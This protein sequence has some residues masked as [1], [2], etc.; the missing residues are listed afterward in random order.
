[1]SEKV[2]RAHTSVS[3]RARAR[4]NAD[5][6]LVF[7]TVVDNPFRVKWPV[8]PL[9]VQNAVL[10]GVV[11]MLAVVAEYNVAREQ[12]SRRKRKRSHSTPHGREAERANALCAVSAPGHE[13]GTNDNAPSAASGY[14]RDDMHMDVPHCAPPILSSLTVGINQVTKRLERLACSYR[15]TM[16]SNSEKT[17]TS[18]TPPPQCSYLVLACRAD[19]DPPNLIG[20]I[21]NLVAALNSWR[22]ASASQRRT[23]LV[24]LPKGAEPTLA[25]ALGLRRASIML[26][27]DSA[28][29]FLT[30]E[31]LL[32]SIPL[33]TAPW[34]D[35]THS[36]PCAALVPT[37]F[38]QL[39]TWAPKDMKANKEKRNQERATALERRKARTLNVPKRVTVTSV[40]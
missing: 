32:Q 33:L 36:S 11:N 35:S 1:M 28:P 15:L 40:S 22:A 29:R 8:I 10:A 5:R 14:R 3:N 18:E 12:T 37:H 27:E 7:R 23:W 19:V 31:P 17:E 20:H 2:A 6:K 9:N 16:K 26:I 30:L 4:E 25:E 24:P 34:L 13:P 21:P 39:R 38:K